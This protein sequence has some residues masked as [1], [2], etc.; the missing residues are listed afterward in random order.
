MYISVKVVLRQ[1]NCGLRRAVLSKQR[2]QV[3]ER[4]TI[5]I[6]NE[7]ET[8]AVA[9]VV[10]AVHLC[11]SSSGVKDNSSS[12]ITAEYSGAFLEKERKGEFLHYLKA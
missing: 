1:F 9:V 6:T 3:Q 11:V 5:Q 12:T 4:L 8:D 2:P 10:D 7:L